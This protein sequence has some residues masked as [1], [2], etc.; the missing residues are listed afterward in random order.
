M[1][2]RPLNTLSPSASILFL[3][4]SPLCSALP[5]HLDLVQCPLPCCR[6]VSSLALQDTLPAGG[7]VPLL[8]QTLDCKIHMM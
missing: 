5:A 4:L 1:N 2:T 6:A 8:E 3:H 7:H